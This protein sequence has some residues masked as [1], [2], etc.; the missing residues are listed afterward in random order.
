MLRRSATTV[1]SGSTT[2]SFST[3]SDSPVSAD[4]S[5]WSSASRI[6]LRSAGSLSP[7]STSTTSPGTSLSEGTCRWRPSRSTR[8]S[9]CTIDRSASR[10]DSA[11]DS[12]MN[13]TTVLT[14][15]TPKMTEASTYSPRNIVTTPATIRT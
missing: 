1:S 11:L 8:A 15:T 2:S 3:G 5:T 7:A 9:V 14:T 10:A 4:S 13:P 12:W 6:N